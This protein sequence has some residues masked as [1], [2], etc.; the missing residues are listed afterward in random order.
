MIVKNTDARDASVNT[1]VTKQINNNNKNF[2]MLTKVQHCF[3][4]CLEVK[5]KVRSTSE[6][7]SVKIRGSKFNHKMF[8]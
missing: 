4:L 8:V 2:S 1:V 6:S 7:S 3:D 5:L